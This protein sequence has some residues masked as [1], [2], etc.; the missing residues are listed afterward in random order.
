KQFRWWWSNPH[1]AVYD[2]GDGQGWAPHGPQTQW[3]ACAK[4]LA[5][6]EYGFPATDKA[7][8]QP[9]VFFDSRSSESATPYWSLWAEAAGGGFLPQRDDTLMMLALQAVNEYWNDDGRNE[10]SPGGVKLIEFAFSCVWAWDARPFPTFPLLTGQWSDGA[11][12]QAGNWLSGRGPALPPPAASPAPT[13]GSYS[14]FP[15]LA[16][17]GWSTHVKPRF[18]T[19]IAGRASGRSSRRPLYAAALYDIELSYDLLRGNAAHREMQEIAG[20]FAASA[21]RSEPFW[22]APPGLAEVS[23]QTLGTGDG[24]KT[25]FPLVRSLG[26]YVEQVAA[27][28]GV[29]AVSINGAVAPSAQY[30][31]TSG[32]GPSIVFAAPPPAGAAI[33]ADF[34]LLWL[35]RFS[36]DALDLDEFMTMLF[37]LGLVKLQMVRP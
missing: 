24:A 8:N 16:A 25:I 5:F 33:A 19:L 34:G 4:P 17:L 2:A 10:T 12:W 29:A 32:Y 6:I 30:S 13:P 1:R 7:T 22:L 18:A 9:N 20:F 26:T 3:Q 15:S 14:T 27:T 35:C 28:S 11:N 21:G 23:G 37:E 36:D 31:V